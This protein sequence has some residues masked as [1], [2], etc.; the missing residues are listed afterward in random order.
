MWWW[1]RRV[2]L[3]RH[4]F[5]LRESCSTQPPR[6]CWDRLPLKRLTSHKRN[7]FLVSIKKSLSWQCNFSLL[8]SFLILFAPL[9]L[10]WQ[11]LELFFEEVRFHLMYTLDNHAFS[12]AANL[13]LINQVCGLVWGANPMRHLS[14]CAHRQYSCVIRVCQ[15][16]VTRAPTEMKTEM[17]SC[18]NYNCQHVLRLLS[19]EKSVLWGMS[20]SLYTE[21]K[22]NICKFLVSRRL[23]HVENN[24]LH[25]VDTRR[26]CFHRGTLLSCICWQ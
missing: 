23:S 9:Y 3:R 4:D 26:F 10:L 19:P 5:I 15:S 14:C 6:V 11:V 17:N 8:R 2:Q 1:A 25:P 18:V 16:L 13:R 12:N 20:R 22:S 21:R 24:K 7:V